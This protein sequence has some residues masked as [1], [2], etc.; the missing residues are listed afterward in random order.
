MKARIYKPS[1]TAMQSGRRGTKA[2]VLEF[3]PA[4]PRSR[5][6]LMGWTSSPDTRQQL[7]LKFDTEEAAIAYCKRNGLDYVIREPKEREIRPKSYAA[8]FRWDRAG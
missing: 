2:W 8:N 4:A 6:P 5:D 7:R 1:K 3:E